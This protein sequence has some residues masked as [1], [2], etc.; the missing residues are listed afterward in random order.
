MITL[1]DIPEQPQNITAVETQSRYLILSWIEPHHNNAPILG[2]FVSYNRPIFAGGESVTL[3]VSE[4]M[5]NVTNLFP[6]FTYSFTVIAYNDIGNSTE[7]E[8][9]P[10]MT[11]E[12]GRTIF[13]FQL[14]SDNL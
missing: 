7:S 13:T 1:T 3:N 10:L 14:L 4:E 9:T 5:A 2:Y 8:A 11:L 6:R 12:E